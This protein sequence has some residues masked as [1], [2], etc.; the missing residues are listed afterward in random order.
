MATIHLDSISK[1]YG[2]HAVFNDLSLTVDHGECFTLL[3]PS[4][5]GKTVRKI[6]I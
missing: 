1:S 5:C 4:D 6:I 3:G 2:K